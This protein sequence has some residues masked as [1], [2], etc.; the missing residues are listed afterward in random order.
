MRHWGTATSTFKSKTIYFLNFFQ[1]TL[2]PAQSLT[3]T[4]CDSLSKET[5]CQYFYATSNFQVVLCVLGPDPDDASPLTVGHH[6]G[7]RN[8]NIPC[9]GTP[10]A[11][12]RWPPDVL[13]YSEVVSTPARS[14]STARRV[15]SISPGAADSTPLQFSRQLRSIDDQLGAATDDAVSDVERGTAAG[16]WL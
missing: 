12:L 7:G 11:V 14:L 5:S 8:D 6:H 2:E 9:G 4:L 10:V 3:A 16:C 13:P 15:P 1:F